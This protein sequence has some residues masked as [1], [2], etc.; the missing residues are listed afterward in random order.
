MNV[1]MQKYMFW[2]FKPKTFIFIFLERQTNAVM[3]HT[4]TVLGYTK[5]KKIIELKVLW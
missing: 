1:T 4:T 2:L 5:K 3:R